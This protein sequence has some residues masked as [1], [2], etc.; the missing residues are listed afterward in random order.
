MTQKLIDD[1]GELK[2]VVKQLVSCDL[3]QNARSQLIEQEKEIKRVQDQNKGL[4]DEV[5][6]YVQVSPSPC[7]FLEVQ[8][9][10][11]AQR[12]NPTPS[13]LVTWE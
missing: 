4:R 5:K 12:L 2:L 6:A 1:K 13:T 9:S 8:Y 7:T 11:R 3:Y 10:A